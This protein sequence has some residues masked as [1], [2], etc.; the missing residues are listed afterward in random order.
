M[1]RQKLRCAKPGSRPILRKRWREDERAFFEH[2]RAELWRQRVTP[3]RGGGRSWAIPYAIVVCESGVRRT[4]PSGYYGI[5]FSASVPT[6]Q[7][8]GDP[9]FAPSPGEAS[10]RE[11]DIV[12]HRLY[13]ALGLQPWECASIVGLL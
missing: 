6:W 10:K 3:F 5:L 4:V 11:Q 7:T 13:Q 8:W 2:R 1:Q 12:A 9:G